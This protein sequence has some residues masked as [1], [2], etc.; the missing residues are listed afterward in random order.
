MTGERKVIYEDSLRVSAGMAAFW[1]VLVTVF[2]ILGVAALLRG[3]V[4]ASIVSFFLAAFFML[5]A[6]A[7]TPKKLTVY[8]EAVV[9]RLYLGYTVTIT[10]SHLKGVRKLP[11]PSVFLSQDVPFKSRWSVPVH[12][13]QKRGLAY[14]V[15]PSHPDEFVAHVSSIM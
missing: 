12:I 8:R 9:I 10:A 4:I 1:Y 3:T 2:L 14:V 15:T 5:A 6:L 11:R 7:L 13:V